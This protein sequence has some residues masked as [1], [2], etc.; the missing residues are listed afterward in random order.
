MEGS[1]G[2]DPS[3]REWVRRLSPCQDSTFRERPNLDGPPRLALKPLPPEV[4]HNCL[5]ELTYTGLRD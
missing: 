1:T 2:S 5:T 4:T 3:S